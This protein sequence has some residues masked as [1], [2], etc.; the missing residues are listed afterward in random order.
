MQILQDMGT[1][2][3]YVSEMQIDN[4]EPIGQGSYAPNV[5]PLTYDA[6]ST[7]RFPSTSA[8]LVCDDNSTGDADK[9]CSS[10][11]SEPWPGSSCF[12]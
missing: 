2:N 5:N 9:L 10:R 1:P 11:V 4:R 7:G 12:V 6:N 8:S 3:W